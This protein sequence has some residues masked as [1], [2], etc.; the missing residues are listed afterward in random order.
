LQTSRRGKVSEIRGAPMKEPSPSL[1]DGAS[2]E[3]LALAAGRGDGQA[4]RALYLRQRPGV[5]VY[6]TRLFGAGPDREDVIQD[7][8]LQLYR[9]LPNFRGDARLSTFLRRITMNVAFDHLRKRCRLQRLDYDS[10]ALDAAVDAGQDPEQRSS[11]RQQLQSLLHH[12]DG[13]ALDQRHALI[14][15]AV[16]GLSV[17]AAAAQ[18]GANAGWVKLR[19]SRARRELT[20]MAARPRSSRRPRRIEAV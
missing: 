6:V 13:I 7:V 16:A 15:V 17:N 5:L 3:A 11:A 2:D 10:H 14:L 9:A 18:M 12:L 1:E 8:F 19:L 4:F 20:A